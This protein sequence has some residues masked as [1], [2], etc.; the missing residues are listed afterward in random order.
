MARRLSGLLAALQRH[1]GLRDRKA[2]IFAAESEAITAELP[3]LL[4]ATDP[5][6]YR[7]A[8]SLLLD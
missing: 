1:A 2:A 5:A 8:C 4:T 3:K 6:E 7:A